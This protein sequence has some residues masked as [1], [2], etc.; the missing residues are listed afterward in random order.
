MQSSGSHTTDTSSTGGSYAKSLDATP[1][2]DA[3]RTLHIQASSSQENVADGTDLSDGGG[4]RGTTGGGSA[5][6]TTTKGSP[7]V[8]KRQA[9]RGSPLVRMKHIQSRDNM[10]HR[11]VREEGV[12]E[13]LGGGV[14]GGK[15]LG[16]VEGDEHDTHQPLNE[17]RE[18]NGDGERDGEVLVRVAEQGG[19]DSDIIQ[20]TP[21]AVQELERRE[22]RENE[23]EDDEREGDGDTEK[24]EG[25]GEEEED[26]DREGG[27]EAGEGEGEG[28]GEEEKREG[29]GG[30]EREREREGVGEEDREREG[31]RGGEREEGDDGMTT[32]D[33][34][35]EDDELE[36]E[37]EAE[38]EADSSTSPTK[39]NLTNVVHSR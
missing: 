2:P 20:L 38:G 19:E 29:E 25:E 5:P 21:P 22:D 1:S 34:E 6:T 39:G 4:G 7:L 36:E 13:K 35:S 12:R 26:R 32:E 24:E 8:E 31:E 27:K 30:R 10:G 11:P 9:V 37:E 33:D 28:E 15:R 16:S 23:R 18:T 17:I 3:P 14:E